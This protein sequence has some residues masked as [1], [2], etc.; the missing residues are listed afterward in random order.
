MHI[1]AI[2][3]SAL[4]L[5]SG[6]QAPAPPTQAAAPPAQTPVRTIDV[7]AGGSLNPPGLQNQ[8]DVQWLWPT[9]RSTNPLVSGAHVAAGLS[10][11]LSP[12]YT[13]VGPWVEVSPLSILDIRAGVE[14]TFYFGTFGSLLSFAGY[15]EDFSWNSIRARADQAKSGA[16]LRAYIKPTFKLKAGPVM[17]SFSTE[18]ERWSSN[19]SGPLFYEPYWDTLMRAS[20]QTLVYTSA[21]VLVQAVTSSHHTLSVGGLHAFMHVYGTPDNNV[22]R[23][24]PMVVY[25]AGG[26]VL[27]LPRPRVVAS[28]SRYLSDPHKRGG[29]YALLGVTLRLSR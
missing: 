26:R 12:S 9:T 7:T 11:C 24:G 27:G 2:L 15:G 6:P 3:V 18:V 21:A 10:W 1:A 29:Y 4:M 23:V 8:V 19:A 16:A 20:G 5:A 22:Q 14:P 25:E 17:G 28:L 13:R